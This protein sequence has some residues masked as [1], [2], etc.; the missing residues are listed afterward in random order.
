MNLFVS[1]KKIGYSSH[2]PHLTMSGGPVILCPS[3][4]YFT[5]EPTS[6]DDGSAL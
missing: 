1:G 5:A 4:L 3:L 2:L 6:H